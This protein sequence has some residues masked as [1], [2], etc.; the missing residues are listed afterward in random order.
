MKNLNLFILISTVLSLAIA[1]GGGGGG[2]DSSNSPTVTKSKVR[3]AGGKEGDSLMAYELSSGNLIGYA[4]FDSTGSTNIS[5]NSGNTY[6]L[7]YNLDGTEVLETIVRKSDFTADSISVALNSATTWA[8]HK[9][10]ALAPTEN[11]IASIFSNATGLTSIKDLTLSNAPNM[12]SDNRLEEVRLFSLVSNMV[13][14]SMNESSFSGNWL[15]ISDNLLNSFD[16]ENTA[17]AE[18]VL[19]AAT[20]LANIL[21]TEIALSSKITYADL[22]DGLQAIIGTESASKNMLAGLQTG[23]AS[24]TLTSISLSNDTHTASELYQLGVTAMED[25]DMLEAYQFFTAAVQADQGN[26]KAR[27]LL[28]TTR[29]MTLSMKGSREAKEFLELLDLD[30]D[31]LD[32]NHLFNDDGDDIDSIDTTIY[33]DPDDITSIFNY[34][35]LRD[36]VQDV[37]ISEIELSISDLNQISGSA[38]TTD[39][40]ITPAMQGEIDEDEFGEDAL[41]TSSILVDG[42]DARAVK[43]GLELLRVK[44][45]YL[46]SQNFEIANENDSGTAMKDFLIQWAYYDSLFLEGESTYSLSE[47]NIAKAQKAIDSIT[48]FTFKSGYPDE[49]LLSQDTPDGDK[50][51]LDVE[52]LD[53]EGISNFNSF[54]SNLGISDP[55][56]M[57]SGDLFLV[58]NGTN[59]LLNVGGAFEGNTFDSFSL[60]VTEST[61]P[62]GDGN[63]TFS[64]SYT[65]DGTKSTGTLDL[66]STYEP[67]NGNKFL[68]FISAD[69]TFATISGNYNELARTSFS[70][71]LSITVGVLDSLQTELDSN[72]NRIDH[73]VDSIDTLE[74]DDNSIFSTTEID[75]FQVFL[76]GVNS[77]LFE[78]SNVDPTFVGGNWITQELDLKGTFSTNLRKLFTNSAGAVVA[79]SDRSPIT[80]EALDRTVQNGNELFGMT[81]STGLF[82]NV[83]YTYADFFEDVDLWF[84]GNS[85]STVPTSSSNPTTINTTVESPTILSGSAV[86]SDDWN[87]IGT[88]QNG[89][90][91]NSYTIAGSSTPGV[92]TVTS[93]GQNYTGYINGFSIYYK[94]ADT[95][96]GNVSPFSNVLTFTDSSFTQGVQISM[97]KETTSGSGV[98]EMEVAKFTLASGSLSATDLGHTDVT[99]SVTLDHSWKSLTD[100]SSGSDNLDFISNGNSFID[101]SEPNDPSPGYKLHMYNTLF[102]GAQVHTSGNYSIILGVFDE[103][104]TVYTGMELGFDADDTSSWADAI[105][106][107]VNGTISVTHS[108][109]HTYAGNT[110]SVTNSYTPLNEISEIT[111]SNLDIIITSESLS[112][113][114]SDGSGILMGPVMFFG[115][116]TAQDHSLHIFSF[117]NTTYS[118]YY[119]PAVGFDGGSTGWADFQHGSKASGDLT[120][121]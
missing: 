44:L 51:I 29:L 10:M 74:R 90:E 118:N 30:F 115:S 107:E 20:E 14:T 110:L 36:Y 37:L 94:G 104:K 68:D 120:R 96:G 39:L 91:T 32:N 48:T 64:E 65:M 117:D 69:A 8:T 99:G 27:F 85:I 109:V 95:S 80:S 19:S 67:I 86:F 52:E 103:N 105:F 108:P 121:D 21:R 75:K 66:H 2:S 57:I 17:S 25:E 42:I 106:G 41:P 23:D 92:V 60:Q 71:A 53:S 81:V 88:T 5:L 114:S 31:F 97:Q 73:I 100:S 35:E 43:A 76:N 6:I 112:V 38:F 83:K 111:D 24:A 70:N 77:A 26:G 46:L 16:I 72:T 12:L 63:F 9:V 50:N 15:S 28:A 3:M 47:T 45:L 89:S 4:M 116:H 79:G 98:A 13:I 113:N 102:T 18:T 62:D 40:V 54:Y 33:D 87:I 93:N 11:S 101:V 59:T 7:K 22:D 56:Y 49:I 61:D 1:C 84:S 34:E 78:P 119:G 55:L 82:S 58:V